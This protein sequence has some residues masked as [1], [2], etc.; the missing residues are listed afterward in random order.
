MRERFWALLMLAL[1]RCGRQGEALAAY[2]R[3]AKILA[4]ELGVDPGPEL[5]LLHKRILAAEPGLLEPSPLPGTGVPGADL[6]RRNGPDAVVPR[7]LPAPVL[8]LVGRAPQLAALDALAASARAG[9]GALV[10]SLIHGSAGVGKTTLAVHWAHRTADR[11]PDGQLYVNLRGFDLSERPVDSAEAVRGFLDAFHYPG[12]AAT[13]KHGG[14]G[15][16]L[17][18][19]GGR[20]TDAD[21][22]R[23]RPGRWA[24]PRAAARLAGLPSA[25]DQPQQAHR[26]DRGRRRAAN[27]P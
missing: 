21:R 11:F 8:H 12:R 25:G 13:R 19:P 18:Q 4:D 14:A 24:R 1:Y 22:S 27:R 7:Q 23:Q 26:P 2:Q 17:P 16:P 9:P 5:G 15:G 10:I 20:P 3:A 6:A